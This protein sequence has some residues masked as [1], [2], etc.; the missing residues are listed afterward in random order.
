MAGRERIAI[1]VLALAFLFLGGGLVK[2][3]VVN[4]S[5][6]AEQSENNRIRV[7]PM[8]PRRG[9]I[10][11]RE[12][13]VI[14]DNRPSY[15][16]S[17]IPAEEIQGVTVPGL[18]RLIGLDTTEIRRRVVKNTVSRYQ[19]AAVKK[20][21][22][23][24]VVAVLE[25]Q[26]DKFPGVSY[27]MGR[28]RRYLPALGAES[29][30]GHVNE[31]SREELARN[32][33]S[34]LR[35]G[36]MIG[37]KGLERAYDLFLRGIEGT[38]YIEVF[39][40]GQI[41]GP[42]EGRPRVEPIAGADIS[43]T[44]DIDL[45]RTALQALDTFC[46]GAVVAMVPST[47]EIL[48]MTS[49][50]SYDANIFSSVIPTELW[51]RISNDSTHPLLNR[52]LTGQYPPGSTVKFVTVGA[53][54]EEGLI[55]ENSTFKPCLGGFRFGDRV[56]H[57]WKL[58]GHG[59]LNLTGALE[60]SCDIY[61]YQLG[62]QLGVDGLAKYY[63][64]S[65]FGRV[66]GVELAGEMPGLNPDS[67]YYDKRYGK[68]KWSRGLALNNAI[69]QGELLSTPLQLTQFFCGLA[70]NGVVY[71]P[72]LVKRVSKPNGEQTTVTPQISFTLPYSKATLALL[73]NALRL[74]VEGDHGTAKS[75]KNDLYS[76]GGKTGTAQN[77]HGNEHSL[78]VGVA[79]LENPEIV[80]CAIIENAGHGSE[81]AAPVV[82]KII[83][84]YMTKKMGLDMTAAPD[85]GV[86]L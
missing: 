67:E 7:V 18:A 36:S 45:Q 64:K 46:C 61:M 53:G 10:F 76:I 39:A 62:L 20:D 6:L 74:V 15:T 69:G 50:P 9:T 34:E 31:V 68:K 55:T 4:H 8:V 63:G 85:S 66:T 75:L 42:Y 84:A 81:V 79:P 52:P 40:S 5:E 14:V 83:R 25:E 24:D 32:P 60:Q 12:G 17:I 82:G 80:V 59:T 48:V 73:N 37:K 23:F 65:G 47:G 22:S 27:Q 54:L 33:Q 16:V 72:H 26:H 41:R 13:R 28:V 57:C 77:P 44:I 71:R 29:F 30:T 38:A 11:D 78:F 2:L 1:V 51:E 70:N 86:V 21:I 35:A 43:L 19:P 56:F 58:S 49:Y 3:Q